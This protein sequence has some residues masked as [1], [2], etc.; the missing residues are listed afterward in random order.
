MRTLC[1]YAYLHQTTLLLEPPTSSFLTWTWPSVAAVPP[2]FLHQNDTSTSTLT[3]FTQNTP[4]SDIPN[5]QSHAPITL[6]HSLFM[7][8]QHPIHR[9]EPTCAISPHNTTH[10]PRTSNALCFRKMAPLSVPA[11]PAVRDRA[12]GNF[13]AGPAS[14]SDWVMRT[15]AEEFV[16]KDGTGMGI[17]EVR[18]SSY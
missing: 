12:I 1:A 4:F 6:R 10:I 15:A 9:H 14:L 7:Q 17:M 16:N 11:C 13:S 8:H 2:H 3:T 18:R 5:W